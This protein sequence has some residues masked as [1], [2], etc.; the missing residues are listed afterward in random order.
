MRQ[1]IR[2]GVINININ[3]LNLLNLF[4]KAFIFTALAAVLFFSFPQISLAH[5]LNEL[6]LVFEVNNFADGRGLN[7]VIQEDYF[8]KLVDKDLPEQFA[9]PRVKMLEQYLREKKSPWADHA[10]FILTQPN[11]E[12]ILG[13]GF[14]ESN[15]CRY[16]IR[17]HN[18]WGIGGGNPE[19]Y[20]SYQAGIARA[21]ELIQKYH[22]GGLTTAKLMRTRWVG[23]QN[24]SWPIAVEQVM[25]DLQRLGI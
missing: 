3:D 8:G 6:P 16:Q 9:D 17:V 7:P 11:Y 22:D 19:V 5:T 4:D 13:I 25:S 23:W 18:C 20:E 10:D 15:F 2:W 12:F 24:H 21:N 14:A 1:E